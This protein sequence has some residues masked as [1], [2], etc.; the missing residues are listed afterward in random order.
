MSRRFWGSIDMT[1]LLE[2]GK[3]QHS[4]FTRGKNQ[5]AYVNVTVWLND[6]PDEYG[7][8]IAI[9]LQSTKEKREAEGRTYIGN[10]KEDEN[11]SK[12]VTEKWASALP[13]DLDLPPREATNGEAA[14]QMQD[15]KDDLP[16]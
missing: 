14:P 15:P 4:A 9:Q 3:K 6:K 7:N 5:R 2:L 8:M 1:T 13:S 11:Q 12:P 10:C 16:F